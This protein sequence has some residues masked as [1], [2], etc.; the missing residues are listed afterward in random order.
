MLC[1]TDILSDIDLRAFYEA[2]CKDDAIATLAVQWRET[3]RYLLFDPELVL[4]GWGNV[5]TGEI[6]LPR[7]SMLNLQMLAF[8]GLH[9]IDP[10]FFEYLPGEEKFSIIDAYLK[11]SQLKTIRAYRCDGQQWMDVGKK[12]HLETAEPFAKFLL[13]DI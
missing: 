6:K 8:S 13:K 9:V 1:N 3:S 5:K 7:R 11:V 2:H 12:N 10:R 4:N